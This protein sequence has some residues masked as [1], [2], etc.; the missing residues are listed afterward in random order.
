MRLTQNH[1]E[2]LQDLLER[3]EIT[4]EQANVEKVRMARVQLVTGK[5]PAQIRKTLN[6][7]VKRGELGHW[8][9]DGRKPEVYFHP[10]FDYMA[11]KARGEHERNTLNALAGVVVRPVLD[12]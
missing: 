5:L 12:A 2:H 3:G 4:A 11:R 1:I 10:A 8:K 6:A 7:A 9:K